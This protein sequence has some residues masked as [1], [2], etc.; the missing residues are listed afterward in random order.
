M[1]DKEYCCKCG[2]ETGKAG[3]GDDSLF[4]DTG[5]GPYCESCWD[6]I[7]AGSSKETK[8]QTMSEQK[9]KTALELV[10]EITDMNG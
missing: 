9:E 6:K 3:R 2:N 4:T 8:E 10:D 5:E 1:K 7:H